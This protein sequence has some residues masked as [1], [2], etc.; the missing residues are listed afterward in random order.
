MPKLNFEFRITAAYL[1]V[2][3]LWI[4]FSDKFLQHIIS[5][6]N[7]LTEIQTYKGWFYVFVTA[8]LFYSLLKNHLRKLRKAEYD[9][10]ESDRL[11]TA[12]LQNISHEI[13]TPMNGIIGFAQLLNLDDLKEEQKKKYTQFL[14]NSSNRLLSVVNDVLEI[15]LIESGKIEPKKSVF[16]LNELMDE[17]YHT[18][19]SSVGKE[20][21]FTVNKTLSDNASIITSDEV[22][23]RQVI[24]NLLSNAIKFTEKG[25]IRFG[26]KLKNENLEFY[27]EDTGIGIKA[28]QHKLIFDRFIKAES[29]NTKIYDGVGLGLAICKGNIKILEG[30]IWVESQ[31]DV[32]TTFF[33]TIPYIISKQVEKNQTSEDININPKVLTILIIEDDEINFE[34]VKALLGNVNFSLLY[35]KNGLEGIEFCKKEKKLDLV[36]LDLKLPGMNGYEVLKEIRKIYPKIPIIANTAYSFKHEK[37]KALNSGFDYFLSKPFNKNQLLTIINNCESIKF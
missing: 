19:K 33:F 32:G 20:I 34:Y 10:K 9:A 6:I 21:S 18:F 35:A 24:Y 4:I 36:L 11:K 29:N 17:L 15:S 3:S 2:G 27:V 7:L 30:D 26:Y 37:E 12:F 16:T 22:K 8:I 31:T 14:L 5:D 1:I 13:R 25:Y 23:L 28:E